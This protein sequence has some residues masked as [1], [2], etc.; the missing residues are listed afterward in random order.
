[1]G[2]ACRKLRVVT[3]S[4]TRQG[5]L[6]TKGWSQT[7]PDNK[8]GRWPLPAWMRPSAI[9]CLP[10]KG[11]SAYLPQFNADMHPE[12]GVP[13]SNSIW[14]LRFLLW[15]KAQDR[16]GTFPRYLLRKRRRPGLLVCNKR[17]PGPSSIPQGVWSSIR[18]RRWSR[19]GTDSSRLSFCGKKQTC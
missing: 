1:M 17:G 8:T 7:T 3:N 5:W 6:S 10:A 16:G 12:N 19:G 2:Y 9:N 18:E 14:Q 15:W 11:C 4:K 13:P